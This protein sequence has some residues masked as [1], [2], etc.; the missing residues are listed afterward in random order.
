MRWQLAMTPKSSFSLGRMN[1]IF[2]Q[3]LDYYS[4]IQIVVHFVVPERIARCYCII[5]MTAGGS[6]PGI[7]PFSGGTALKK[8]ADHWIL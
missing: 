8:L 1:D 4:L 7:I 5:P 2:R 6:A 3:T